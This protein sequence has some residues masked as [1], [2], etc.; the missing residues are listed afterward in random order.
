M[1]RS[2]SA[3]FS[4]SKPD[5]LYVFVG[6]YASFLRGGYPVLPLAG[7]DLDPMRQFPLLGVLPEPRMIYSPAKNL[8]LYLGG[9]L[10]GGSFRTDRM[11]SSRPHKL[12]GAQ[13]DFSDYRA[14]RRRRLQF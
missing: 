3:E 2:R 9:E 4:F 6:A 11:M 8:D 1:F 7:C 5:K 12:S 14:G 13:V 10:A